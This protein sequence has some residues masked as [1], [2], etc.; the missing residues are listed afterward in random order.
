[1][2]YSRRDWCLLL[3]ALAPALGLG[4]Q[5]A[6]LP[7][8]AARFEDLPAQKGGGNEFRPVLEGE[9]HSGC[10]LEVHETLLAPGSMP[11]PPHHHLHEEMFLIREGTVEATIRGKATRLGPGSV[12][13]V[14]SNEE[15]GIRNAD[16]T[17]AQYF[18]VALG[19]DA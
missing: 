19:K 16:T 5:K 14:A 4:A 13:F 18:V 10:A 11:H 2:T 7:S 8:K 9:T 6:E 15:H 3:S 1:M 17:P 12:A